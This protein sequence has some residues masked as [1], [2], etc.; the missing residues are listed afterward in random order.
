MWAKR[1]PA[2]TPTSSNCCCHLFRVGTTALIA[3]SSHATCILSPLCSESR[4][5]TSLFVPRQLHSRPS[6]RKTY[7]RF[8]LVFSA[9]PN[10]KGSFAVPNP[11]SDH[12]W[13]QKFV[14]SA[15]VPSGARL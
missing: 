4:C 11:A 1:R 3:Y 10:H 14:T 9:L 7:I 5:I 8:N 12:L 6:A 2:A 15:K 13:G